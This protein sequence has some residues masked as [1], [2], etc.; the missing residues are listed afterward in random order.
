MTKWNGCGTSGRRV[1]RAWFPALAGL[2]VMVIGC[3]ASAPAPGGAGSGGEPSDGAEAMAF[4]VVREAFLTPMDTVDNVD[5]PAAWRSPDGEVVLLATA[6]GTHV[7]M[8]YDGV[9]GELIGRWGEEGTGPGQF[10]RPNGILVHDDLLVVVERDNRRVQILR[11]P[12][13]ESLAIFGEE[14]LLKPYGLTGVEENGV[15]HLWVTDDF[16]VTGEGGA[17]WENR[18]KRF[19]VDL[20]G[21]APE[22]QFVG[23]VGE[24]DGPGRLKVVESILADP[25]H[26][27]LFIADEDEAE[28]VIKVYHLAGGFTGRRLG[29]GVF[30]AE[31]EG[32]ALYACGD[33]GYL[34][35]ADQSPEGNRFQVFDR[36][37]MDHLGT[38]TGEAVRNTD[39]VALLQGPVGNLGSGAFYAVHDDQGVVA[40]RWADVAEALGLRGDCEA[41]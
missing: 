21:D 10:R 7:I 26:A 2:A 5:S 25:V 20:T 12:D 30:A 13:F 36:V 11:L 3:E 27:R 29:E 9:T 18:V 23:M 33:E 16:D 32:L 8:A 37:S 15:L 4:P 34:V 41:W 35:M 39:G 14:V 31:P 40:F 28:R 38:F 19:G 24:P 1:K 17:R 6:K 22:A